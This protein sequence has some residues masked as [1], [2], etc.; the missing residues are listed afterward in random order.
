MAHGQRLRHQLAAARRASR[1]PATSEIGSGSCRPCELPANAHN[2]IVQVALRAMP[3][4][5]LRYRLEARRCPSLARVLSGWQ[6]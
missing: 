3:N 2:S 1:H 6:P 4:T 5:Q